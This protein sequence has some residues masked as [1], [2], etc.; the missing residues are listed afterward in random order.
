MRHIRTA[1]LLLAGV[2]TLAVAGAAAQQSSR[3]ARSIDPD[4]TS[5]TLRL[6]DFDKGETVTITGMVPIP[7]VGEG[8]PLFTSLDLK[9]MADDTQTAIADTRRDMRR[10]G[11]SGVGPVIFRPSEKPSLPNLLAQE[12][13]FENSVAAATS[14]AQQ[15]TE[16]AE[17]ARRGAALGTVSMPEVEAA[18]L[19]RQAAVMAL[20][21]ARAQLIEAQAMI[22]DFQ[23]MMLGETGKFGIEWGDLDVRAL[24]RK[25]EGVGLGVAMPEELKTLDIR[26]VQASQHKDKKGK[27]I[28]VVRGEIANNGKM[29]SPVPSL[30]VYLVDE[31]GW[32]MYAST[33]ESS[34][35]LWRNI[36][37]GKSKGFIVEV[38]PA[39]D[40]LKTAVVTFAAKHAAE[41]RMRA[42]LFCSN[43]I[44][45]WNSR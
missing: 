31:R 7:N 29:P 16:R 25:K 37:A 15:V 28:V 1:A 34:G 24:K 20:Q 5:T 42:D 32:V 36:G 11:G 43:A 2:A 45:I 23:S 21:K 27:D 14:R 44:R 9:K 19:D 6:P 12:F 10:C 18:E 8:A 41:P 30:S 33:V 17:G 39:P 22:G 35:A 40:L 38:R 4:T 13:E 3:P 26:N